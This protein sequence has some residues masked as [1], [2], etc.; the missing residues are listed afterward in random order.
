MIVNTVKS[1]N[2][3]TTSLVVI[4]IYNYFDG[5]TKLLSNLYIFRYSKI[6][7]SMNIKSIKK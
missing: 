5:P 2:I 3:L 1:F 7:L 6:I 4:P